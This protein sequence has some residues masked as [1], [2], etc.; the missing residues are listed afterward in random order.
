M[1]SQSILQLLQALTSSLNENTEDRLI[2]KQDVIKYTDNKLPVAVYNK[3]LGDMVDNK[4]KFGN[5]PKKHE[6]VK[7]SEK[8]QKL[9]DDKALFHGK[10]VSYTFDLRNNK[11]FDKA[12]TLELLQQEFMKKTNAFIKLP[13]ADKFSSSTFENVTETIDLS[14]NLGILNLQF[15]LKNPGTE[16]QSDLSDFEKSQYPVGVKLVKELVALRNVQNIGKDY[17][18]MNHSHSI[19]PYLNEDTKNDVNF[20]INNAVDYKSMNIKGFDKEKISKLILNF[21]QVGTKLMTVSDNNLPDSSNND[22]R[23]ESEENVYAEPQDN[24]W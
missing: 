17:F 20:G 16:T 4:S 9:F 21:N 18:S 7:I 2:N 14:Q 6:L 10:V 11:K 23:L 22:Q 12:L 1:A 15:L 24:D 19:G 8:R 5:Y 3:L 13:F